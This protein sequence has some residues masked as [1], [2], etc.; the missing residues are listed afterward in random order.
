[1]N[2]LETK[3]ELIFNVNDSLALTTDQKRILHQRLES[4]INMENE[5]VVSS[6]TYRSQS[7]NRKEAEERLIEMLQKAIRPV[8][9][10]IPTKVSRAKKEA[11]LKE[12][13]K[14]SET[15]ANR[16]INPTDL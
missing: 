13:K 4:R 7:R 15:K 9:K 10:R 11:R 16:R 3:V 12:K 5:I 1:M 8:K 14:R 6:Q 2:K